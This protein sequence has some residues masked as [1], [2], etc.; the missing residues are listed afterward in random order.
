MQG[1]PRLDEMPGARVSQTAGTPTF[2]WL[3]RWG[4]A[5]GHDVIECSG[6][7]WPEGCPHGQEERRLI[8][9]R[10]CVTHIA[11]DGLL[12]AGF[13]WED[14]SMPAL[15]PDDL[16]AVRDPINIL[17]LKPAHLARAEA[18]DGQQAQ[19]I[20]PFRR[21]RGASPS[22]VVSKRATVSHVGPIGML[23][24]RYTR[25][26]RIAAASP[27]RTQPFAS[28]WRNQ[29]RRATAADRND[30]RLHRGATSWKYASR[31]SGVTVANSPL[32]CVRQD[33]NRSI[34]HRR[35]RHVLGDR[36]R[37]R[38]SAVTKSFTSPA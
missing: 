23:S 32:V 22:A 30:T 34:C 5:R 14:V 35:M 11:A 10:P 8:A 33:R 20:A 2:P 28:Q 15:G 7:K 19:S 29:I 9:L 4:D 31:C 26:T 13:E 37:S 25:G 16:D 27:G 12:D 21:C 18:I 17:H 38:C 24:S 6:G 1:Q 3:V 36:N